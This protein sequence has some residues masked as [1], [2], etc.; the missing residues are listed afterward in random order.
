VR[1]QHGSFQAVS[2]A[3]LVIDTVTTEAD[4]TLIVVHPATRDAACPDCGL[5][6]GRLHS[7]YERR[8][9]DLPSHGRSVHFLVKFRW[10]SCGN[11][12]YQ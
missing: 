11:R 9:L 6:S 7:R 1:L 12:G 10:F 2:P 4:R 5:T 8:L 3:G